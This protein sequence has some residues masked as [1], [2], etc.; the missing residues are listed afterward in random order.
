M[1]AKTTISL[2]GSSLTPESP[3]TP[4]TETRVF[5]PGEVENGNVH[6]F[7]NNYTGSTPDTMSK[8]TLSLQPPKTNSEICRVVYTLALPLAQ[9]VDGVVSR[10]H[11]NRSKT[12]YI[13]HK[14]STRDERRDMRELNKQISNS[15]EVADMVD[16]I[17]GL[18]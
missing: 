14:D 15:A 10:A 6:T 3:G 2:T 9:T 18:Y 16:N 13:F 1:S 11:V 8:L 17:Y 7:Y 4:V 5:T 12:E